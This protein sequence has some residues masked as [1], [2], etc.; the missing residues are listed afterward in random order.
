MTASSKLMGCLA[1]SQAGLLAA[2]EIRRPF[3]DF[4]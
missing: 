3:S 4:G 2:F 1:S